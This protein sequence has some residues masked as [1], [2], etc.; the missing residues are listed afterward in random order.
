MI[1]FKTVEEESVSGE[2]KEHS[3]LFKLLFVKL[4]DYTFFFFK[5]TEHSL[6]GS[7]LAIE[8]IGSN[9]AIGNGY[10]Y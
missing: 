2:E 3:N 10:V 4:L 8:Y 7:L 1:I 6:T 9:T 5:I